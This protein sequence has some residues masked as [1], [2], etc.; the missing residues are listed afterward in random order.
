[1]TTTRGR[2]RWRKEWNARYK[3]LLASKKIYDGI[4]KE[5]LERILKQ[6]G[7]AEYP[8]NLFRTKTTRDLGASRVAETLKGKR[9]KSDCLL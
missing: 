9:S 8:Y 6:E 4:K 5:E 7:W 1:M 3:E 2:R